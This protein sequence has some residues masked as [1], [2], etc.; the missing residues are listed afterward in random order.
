MLKLSLR[1]IQISDKKYFAKWWRNKELLKLTSGVLGPISNKKVEKYFSA[2]FKNNED[3]HFVIMLNRKAIGH[4]ALAKRK[5]GWH[6]TQIIIGEK[7]Y[8]SKG[9]GTKAIQLLIK[10]AKQFGVSKIYLE[11]RPNNIRAVKTYEKCGFKKSEIKKYPKNHNVATAWHNIYTIYTA[12]YKTESLVDFRLEYPDYPFSDIVNQEIALS[13]K[14]LFGVRENGKWGFADSTGTVVIPCTYEWVEDF[15]E[16][17]AECGLNGKSGFIN[18]AGKLMVP[19]FYD[20]VEPFRHGLCVVQQNKKCGIINK[21]AKLIV[22]FE[23]DEISG[24][25]GAFY[26]LVPD[27]NVFPPDAGAGAP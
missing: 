9:Y 5:N 10:K 8:W 2:L 20:Q 24:A 23:Y 21:N 4:I 25:P 14:Q 22:P 12:D 6:E 15:S 11:V 18:K 16:G 27:V 19:F 7:E 13:Q 1:K 26:S 17:F 3:Y